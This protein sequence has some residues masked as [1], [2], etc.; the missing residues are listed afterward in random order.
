MFVTINTGAAVDCSRCGGLGTAVTKRGLLV[1]CRICQKRNLWTPPTDSGWWGLIDVD[2]SE[3]AIVEG[4]NVYSWKEYPPPLKTATEAQL[5][6]ERFGCSL[7]DN[8]KLI[9]QKLRQIQTLRKEI[10]KL[11]SNTTCVRLVDNELPDPSP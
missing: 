11:V 6:N 10:N 7:S 5:E 9:L 3:H 4:E 2:M 1:P 8:E